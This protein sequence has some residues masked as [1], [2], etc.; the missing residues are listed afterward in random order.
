[1]DNL[2]LSIEALPGQSQ[3]QMIMTLKGPLILNN[4][5]N[6]QDA[7]R[8]EKSPVVILDF[9]DVPYMDSAGLGS[10]LNAHVSRSNSGRRL[11]LAAVP[12]RVLTMIRVARVDQVLNIFPTLQEAKEKMA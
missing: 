7:V 4:L 6:F 3:G 1:M 8:A 9:S 2:P 5:F 12:E 10:I 11:A